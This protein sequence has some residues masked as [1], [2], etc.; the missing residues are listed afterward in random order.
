[1]FSKQQIKEIKKLLADPKTDA[2]KILNP[3]IEQVIEN[4]YEVFVACS[5][6]IDG[7]GHGSTCF[8]TPQVF[9]ALITRQLYR[10]IQSGEFS[11]EDALSIIEQ[12]IN[13]Y[14]EYDAHGIKCKIVMDSVD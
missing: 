14:S 4:G 5:S 13:Q 3:A 2:E 8:M 12:G 7:L 9:L 11:K 6:P 10:M 1:M